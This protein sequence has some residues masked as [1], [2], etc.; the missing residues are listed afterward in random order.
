MKNLSKIIFV[1]ALTI[2]PLSIAIP[3]IPVHEVFEHQGDGF[4]KFYNTHSH[5]TMDITYKDDD[6]E[7]L[8]DGIDE[9]EYILRCRMTN[10][11]ISMD[12]KLIEVI[13]KIQDHFDA[14]EVHIISGYRSP[15]L[16]VTLRAQGRR[17][18]SRSLHMNGMA[19]DIRIPGVSTRE[20]RDYARS[21]KAGGVGYYAGPDFVHIDVGRVR[22]W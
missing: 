8:R 2:W 12:L 1:L 20:L 10:E 18:A 11:E 17:V 15:T 6:G 22:Y 21:L 3:S 7:Y 16:N 9:I 4:L 14:E 13:D 5:E 19:I